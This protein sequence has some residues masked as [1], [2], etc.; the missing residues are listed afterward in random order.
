[1]PYLIECFRMSDRRYLLIFSE[2]KIVIRAV[3]IRRYMTKYCPYFSVLFRNTHM[4]ERQNG[5]MCASSS[6]RSSKAFFRDI[7]EP[8]SKQG[9][10][11]GKSHCKSFESTSQKMTTTTLNAIIT[12]IV[13][14]A[15]KVVFV[16]SYFSFNIA[17]SYLIPEDI[18]VEPWLFLISSYFFLAP[19]VEIFNILLVWCGLCSLLQKS[20]FLFYPS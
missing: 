18:L 11:L 8:D 20:F 17:I 9:A 3:C 2:G 10:I 1:M 6:W 14:S 4:V 7:W 15:I 16:K 19:W 12:M 5:F 13:S